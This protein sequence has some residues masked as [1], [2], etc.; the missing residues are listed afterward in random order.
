M[1]TSK[2]IANHIKTI[3]NELDKAK[4]EQINKLNEDI[5]HRRKG[6][7]LEKIKNGRMRTEEKHSKT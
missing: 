4:Q 1:P 6:V 7:G 5:K 2:L 3:H